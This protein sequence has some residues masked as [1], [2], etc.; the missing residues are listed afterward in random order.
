ML[1]LGETDEEV[2][3]TMDDLIEAGVDFL[4]IGQY[5]QPSPKHYQLREWVPMERF[6]TYYNQAMA[7]GFKFVASSPLVRSS[8][9]ASA[10]LA[11]VGVSR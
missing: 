4:S 8:Y 1:G 9:K 5:V 2:Y 7:K 11:A 10:E 6:Q 3:Q